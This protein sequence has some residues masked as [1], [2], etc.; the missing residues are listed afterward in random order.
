MPFIRAMVF[1]LE[2][3]D[4]AALCAANGITFIGPRADHIHQMGNKL[5]A[6]AFAGQHGIPVLPGSEKISTFE[7]GLEVIERIGF[8]VMM[9]AAAG[10][11][12][13]GMKI[14]TE[15]SQMQSAF[16]SASAEARSAF[17]DETLYLERYISNARH[18]E[19]QVLGDRHGNVIHLGERD[20]SLQRRHQKVIEEAPAPGIPHALC[21]EIRQAAVTLARSMNYESAGTIEFIYDE[22][23]KT[24]YF[25]EMN[26][27]I[28][29]EHPVTEMITGVDLV[30]QQ[31]RVA[32]GEPLGIGQSNVHFRG[33]AIECRITAELPYE[34]FRP[35]PGR[36]TRWRPPEGDNLRVDTHCF[37]GYIV[38][39]H[40]DS[41]LAKLIAYGDDRKQAIER[42]LDALARFEIDGVGTTLPFLKFA[43]GHPIFVEQKMNTR[44]V[45]KM[46]GELTATPA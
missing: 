35:C 10:G 11:G 8:P 45:D 14:V 33:H 46:I 12:G 23:T 5:E 28:Q 38:P 31:L 17:G 22:D 9:K 3:A 18:I 24:F 41:L 32:S 44:V 36:I 6:R 43:I 30:Q 1:F 16:L 39:I 2:S 37:E 21:E 15:R 7:E 34:N 26:T 29:V 42:M 27:R 20:C 13:R 40:Y 4:L 25:L 19:V